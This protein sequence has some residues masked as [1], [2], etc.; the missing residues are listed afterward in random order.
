MSFLDRSKLLK[1]SL[2]SINSLHLYSLF[3]MI[4]L[5]EDTFNHLIAFIQISWSVGL[6]AIS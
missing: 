1:I 5:D 2:T 3:M 4:G 6:N